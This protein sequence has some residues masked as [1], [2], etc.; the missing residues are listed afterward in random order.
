MCNLMRFLPARKLGLVACIDLRAG[1]ARERENLSSQTKIRKKWK[2][3]M[4]GKMKDTQNSRDHSS[5][6]KD[7]A[8]AT[9]EPAG[10]F[11]LVS[12]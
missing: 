9:V 8:E 10:F 6:A 12:S 1:R 3:E 4:D 7:E 2:I 11:D 5:E